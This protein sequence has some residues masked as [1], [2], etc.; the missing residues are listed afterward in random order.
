[1][2]PK[3]HLDPRQPAGDAVRGI[4]LTLLDVLESNVEGTV[5]GRDPK[6]LHDLRVACRRTRSALS[7]LNKVLPRDDVAPFATEFKWLG[8][9]TGPLRDLDV[10]LASLPDLCSML[11]TETAADLEPLELIVHRMRSD[12]QSAVSEA[13]RSPRF[14]RL[15]ST[16]RTTLT[17]P[18]NAD[19]PKAK[20]PIKRIADKRI[21]RAHRRILEHGR[22]Y[23]PSPPAA[24][25]HRLRIDGK[26]LRYL[27][28]FFRSLYHGPL[29]GRLVTE[30]KRLQDILGEFNDL[31]VQ[32]A[33]LQDLEGE[34]GP[35]PS[36]ATVSV[37][38]IDRLTMLT[39]N[40]QR[41]LRNN[42]HHAF[43]VFSAPATRQAYH[44]LL[45]H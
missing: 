21:A 8:D 4:L 23:G 2:A 38:I 6:H 9:M 12:A 16:W 26:K 20:Q 10:F 42:V 32:R 28:E 3:I 15:V 13:L 11:D 39:E 24:A 45:T 31:E 40:R 37:E 34:P 33:L 22:A 43:E 18:P 5:A 17:T 35:A 19:P 1:V 44:R 36:A 27:L 29:I 25:L 7:Q 30:L 14:V 41:R